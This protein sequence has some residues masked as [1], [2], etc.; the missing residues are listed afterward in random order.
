[1]QN[2]DYPAA[3][4]LSRL[5]ADPQSLRKRIEALPGRFTAQEQIT[6][7]RHT[8]PPASMGVEVHDRKHNTDFLC[9]IV[10]QLKS[11]AFYW[12]RKLWQARDVVYER[13]GKRFSFDLSLAQDMERFLLVKAGWK[14]DNCA[15]CGWELFETDDLAHSWG[16]TNGAQWVCEEC[17]RRFIAGD[18][19][20]SSYSDLT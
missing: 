14:K 20:S 12:E 18:F 9:A 3:K 5:G 13:N 8:S 2:S 16:F 11:K 6:R 10:S 19:F 17:Y 15:V 1:V 4:L 7:F